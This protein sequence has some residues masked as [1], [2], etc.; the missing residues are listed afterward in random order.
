[1]HRTQTG[2]IDRANNEVSALRTVV[3]SL[4]SQHE[5]MK[6][7]ISYLKAELRLSR[8][9]ATIVKANNAT[10][11]TQVSH[12][13]EEMEAIEDRT[14][15][16][17]DNVLAP[18]QRSVELMGEVVAELE[19]SKEQHDS[20]RAEMAGKFRVLESKLEEVE[21]KHERE[22]EDARK[23]LRAFHSVLDVYLM[24]AAPAL[25]SASVRANKRGAKQ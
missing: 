4:L 13:A 23:V 1:M 5:S 18:L 17:T 9:E 19:E 11:S 7:E 15:D 25:E 8:G 21:E 12:I 20:E 22:M 6:H 10:Q 24:G 16:T 14:Q 3:T 2:E